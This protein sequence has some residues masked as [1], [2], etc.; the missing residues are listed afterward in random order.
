MLLLKTRLWWGVP[1]VAALIAALV[2][3]WREPESGQVLQVQLFKQ[4]GEHGA[5]ELLAGDSLV[6]GDE[7]YMTVKPRHALHLYVVSEDA[8][9][10]RLLIYP[11]RIWGRSPRLAAH[12][13][14]RLPG[15]E[16]FWPVRSVTLRERLLVIASTRSIDLL[17]AAFTAAESPEPCAGPVSR[18]ASRWIDGLEDPPA[19]FSL[20]ALWKPGDRN[21]E[22]WISILDLKGAADHG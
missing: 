14:Y 21:P 22:T 13:P 2:T 7:L 9:G 11:C 5:V 4:V 18:E 20:G 8:I 17:D 1:V 19:S 15:R 10:E 3:V 16:W 12:R 6:P